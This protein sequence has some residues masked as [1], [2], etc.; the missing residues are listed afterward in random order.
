MTEGQF[1][2]WAIKQTK[3]EKKKDYKVIILSVSISFLVL[4]QISQ[5]FQSLKM[6]ASKLCKSLLCKSE[7]VRLRVRWDEAKLSLTRANDGFLNAEQSVLDDFS[8]RLSALRALFKNGQTSKI[9]F[10][11]VIVGNK[12]ARWKLKPKTSA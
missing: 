6:V 10:S 3:K 1:N 9:G 4:C 8:G 2:M 11:M 7:E 5:L 12:P